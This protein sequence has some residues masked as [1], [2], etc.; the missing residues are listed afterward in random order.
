MTLIFQGTIYSTKT[1]EKEK[2]SARM[3]YL[4]KIIRDKGL[5]KSVRND[6]IL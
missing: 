5:T 1:R 2:I 3:F 6:F 4:Q